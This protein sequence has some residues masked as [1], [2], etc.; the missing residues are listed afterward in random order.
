MKQ[1]S[2]TPFSPKT[3]NQTANEKNIIT[4]PAHI[5]RGLKEKWASEKQN[6]DTQ[7]T[8]SCK[9]FKLAKLNIMRHKHLFLSPVQ[10]R[11]SVFQLIAFTYC[12]IP[13]PTSYLACQNRTPSPGDHV[14]CHSR[15]P[16]SCHHCCWTAQEGQTATGLTRTP[17][18]PGSGF[19]STDG[20]STHLWVPVGPRQMGKASPHNESLLPGTGC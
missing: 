19:H 18:C 12:A 8:K 13:P 5:S 1:S 3:T 2:Q 17:Q 10:S 7:K 14:C 11:I 16:S 20:P 15:S 4:P 9:M 6:K